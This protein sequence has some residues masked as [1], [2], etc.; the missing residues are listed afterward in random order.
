MGCNN[1][2]LAERLTWERYA[3]EQF[4]AYQNLLSS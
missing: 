3:Q 4:Q 1:R 2:R